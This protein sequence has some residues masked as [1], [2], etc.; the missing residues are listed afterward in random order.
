VTPALDASGVTHVAHLRG[1]EA[2]FIDVLVGFVPT[3]S[4]LSEPLR[5]P[6]DDVDQIRFALE[7][8]GRAHVESIDAL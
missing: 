4:E 5:S 7:G 2:G 3:E 8:L 1:N 6:F